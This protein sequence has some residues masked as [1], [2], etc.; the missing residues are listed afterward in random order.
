MTKKDL[1]VHALSFW[2]VPYIWG[3]QS[4]Q[5]ADCSGLI[6]LILEP[7]GLDPKGDQ[8]AHGLYLHFSEEG[9]GT[10]N[11]G[12]LGALAFFGNLSRVVHVGFC[13]D[14]QIM[15]NAS[16]GN[17]NTRTV[18]DALK[19]NAKAKIEPLSRRKDLVAII[20]P[21]YAQRGIF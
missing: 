20:M 9:Q 12:G 5:G 3:G 6:Q 18:Q 2:G 13:I 10:K 14:E 7:T 1:Y 15:L 19:L 21:N 8:S 4:R 16:G 17:P 11:S